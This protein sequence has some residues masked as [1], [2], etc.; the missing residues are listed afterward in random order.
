[1]ALKAEG[2]A[3][4][5]SIGGVGGMSVSVATLVIGFVVAFGMGYLVGRR[6]THHLEKRRDYDVIV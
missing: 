5:E 3:C 1:M 6:K 2:G 4:N